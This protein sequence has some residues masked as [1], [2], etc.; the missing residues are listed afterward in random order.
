M[1]MPDAVPRSR[2]VCTSMRTT[3]GPIACATLAN[4]RDSARAS[5]GASVAGVT[6]ATCPPA[7]DC[8]PAKASAT[9]TTNIPAH[10]RIRPPP[11]GQR[12]P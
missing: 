6:R 9:P 3:D 11:C 1:T 7:A 4:A 2:A 10:V 12:K 8:A 5:L